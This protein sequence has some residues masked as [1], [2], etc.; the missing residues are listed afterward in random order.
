MRRTSPRRTLR[1]VVAVTLVAALTGCAGDGDGSGGAGDSG[2]SGGSEESTGSDAS[3]GS[4]D[5]GLQA[6]GSYVALGDSYT[7]A[8]L[9]GSSTDFTDGCFRSAEN[10][11]ALVAERLSLELTD[12][13]CGGATTRDLARGQATMTGQTVPPQLDAVS[14]DTDLV[15]I[16]LGGN[17]FGLFAGLVQGCGWTVSREQADAPCAEVAGDDPADAERTMDRIRQRLV[18]G[19]DAVLERAPQA[20]VVVVG[21]PQIAPERG[22]CASLPVARGDAGVARTV[23]EQLTEQLRAAATAAGVEYVDVFAATEGHDLCSD[24]PWIAD[25]SVRPPEAAPYHPLA[26]EQEMVADLLVELLAG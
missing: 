1:A 12:V 15:T 4:S 20:R 18:A 6:G 26:P 8:P 5:A 24:D 17:D 23:N 16:S 10:Y 9:V 21:Y 22:G 19:I 2:G 7:A 3:G 11:P 13:S 25:G 14:A